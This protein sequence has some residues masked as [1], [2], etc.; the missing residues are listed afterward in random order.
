MSDD[1]SVPASSVS[2]SLV[3][4]LTAVASIS[5]HPDEA[6]AVAALSAALQPL[7]EEQLNWILDV[8]RRF[9]RRRN[10]PAQV[11]RREL[12]TS[13]A[14]Q[15][16]L[17]RALDT[18][19][20]AS[21]EEK[22]RAIA[23]SIVEGF[24]SDF[25]AARENDVLRVIADLDLAHVL[26]LAVLSRPRPLQN[27]STLLGDMY[28]EVQDLGRIDERLIGL[29]ERLMSVLVSQGLATNES[30]ATFNS[31]SNNYRITAFGRLVLKRFTVDDV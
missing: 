5:G 26:A 20:S 15:E 18:A 13:P 30:V 7:F 9:G 16:L 10:I 21:T 29:E 27:L 2:N 19:R 31:V 3:A 14:K 24:E 11:L 17:I 23:T 4:T 22:R 28:F 25:D 8:L 12:A 1:S 6:V